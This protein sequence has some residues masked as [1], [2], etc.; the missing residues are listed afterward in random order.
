M[1]KWF[2]VVLMI[3]LLV[4]VVLLPTFNQFTGTG[5]TDS[6]GGFIVIAKGKL[7]TARVDIQIWPIQNSTQAEPTQVTFPNGTTRELASKMSF[8]VNLPS[9]FNSV[10]YSSRFN[11]CIFDTE[12]TLPY[13]GNPVSVTVVPFSWAFR[14]CLYGGTTSF[15]FYVVDLNG[16]AQ[17]AYEVW[18]AG[19]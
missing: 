2:I 13:A 8:N 12:G 15:S 18:G 19:F 17:V 1:R 16:S 5:A 6:T 3:A 9:T 14:S 7:A 10:S 4:E 11:T